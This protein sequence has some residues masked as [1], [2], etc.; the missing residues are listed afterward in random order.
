MQNILVAGGAGYIGSHVCKALYEAGFSPVTYDNLCSGNEAA[1][2][3]GPF[4]KGDIRD[5]ARLAE[6][7]KKY[8]PVAVMH[9]AAL[10]QVGDS[11]ENPA[12]YYDNNV[13]GSY[14]LLEQA[15]IHNIQNMV[16][17]STAA[18]YGNPQSNL[19]D[20]D[21]PLNPVN[22]Y[23]HTKLAMENMIRDYAAAYSLQ[24]AILRYFNAAGADPQGETGTAYKKDTHIIPLLMQTA[25]GD[26][27]SISIFGE[28]YPTRDGTAIRDYI[29]VSDL[30]DAHVRALKHL[31]AGKGSLTLN[32]GTSAGFSVRQVLET[33]RQVTGQEIKAEKNPRRTGDPTVLVANADA[34]R[35][36][37]GWQPVLSE[38]SIIVDTAWTWQ[39]KKKLHGKEG[40]FFAQDDERLLANG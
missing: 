36:V 25:C 8:R 2:K 31:L 16:F 29:H 7:M 30:A 22:P 9:F 26:R 20:E 39:Q 17:S 13:F 14:C 37:L 35:S 19:I 4:E 3:W 11:V 12:T 27:E 40:A 10:I 24:Y 38:L 1:V 5:P 15:R 18:V 33:A 6:V 23:G 28:D 32:L 21:H 34:A